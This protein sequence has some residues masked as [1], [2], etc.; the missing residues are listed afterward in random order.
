MTIG[1]PGKHSSG[2]SFREN[3][4]NRLGLGGDEATRRRRG[5]RSMSVRERRA[6]IERRL[7]SQSLEAR[8]LLAGPE[9]VGIQPNSGELI[10]GGTSIDSAPLF[11]TDLLQTAP[12]ELR[13]R[14]DS[15]SSIDVATLLNPATANDDTLLP[16]G[17]SITRA[18]SDQRFETAT[19]LTD[20]GT[21][22]NATENRRV[23]VEFRAAA[24]GVSGNG[25]TVRITNASVA[26]SAA[27]VVIASVDPDLKTIDIRLNTNSPRPATVSDL[28]ETLE[29]HPTANQV[30]TAYSV[31]GLTTTAIN[32]NL[33][34]T[35]LT[36]NLDGANTARATTDLG[37]GDTTQVRFLANQSGAA[38]RDISIRITPANLGSSS[39][40]LVSV[41]NNVINVRINST[42]GAQTTVGQLV[43]A[44][45]NSATAA[46][47]VTASL[48][49]GSST[50]LIST[51][52]TTVTAATPTGLPLTG[53]SDTV[54]S[55][56]FVGIGDTAN[57]VVFRFAEPLP[58]D[59]YQIEIYGEGERALLNTAGEAFNDGE[60]FAVQF[61]I[62]AAPQVLA[63]VPEPVTK[64]SDG[65]LISEPNVIEVYFTNDVN[66][67][68]LNAN[69]Y[70][71]VFTR[72]TVTG[73]DDEAIKPIAVEALDG[74]TDAVRV[75][76]N[77]PFSRTP[78]P[79]NPGSSIE[80]SVRF[81]IGDSTAL[82]AAPIETPVT[83]AESGDSIYRNAASPIA[84]P[85][86]MVLTSF[87]GINLTQ[88]SAIRLTGGSIE[89]AL[90]EILQFPGGS[91]YEGV[92]DIR[93]DDPTSNDRVV[94]LGIWRTDGDTTAGIS[95]I[96]YN[97]PD[98]WQGE[99]FGTQTTDLNETY[100]NAI[101]EQQKERVREVASLFSEY[102]GIQFIEVGQDAA[103]AI[104]SPD[105]TGEVGPVYSIGVGELSSTFDGTTARVNSAA[106]GVTVASRELDDQGNTFLPFDVDSLPVNGNQLI[107]LDGQDFDQSTDDFTG[108]EFFRGVFLGIGQLLG[109]GYAD[110]LPQPIT[111]STDSV[112][113]PT[114]LSQDAIP[115]TTADLLDTNESL[116]PSP[117]DIVNG[118]FLYRPESNDIDLYQFTLANKGTLNISTI[119]ERLASSST[120]DTMLRLYK[121]EGGLPIEIAANDDYFSNDSMIEIEVEK[122]T[123]V[124]GVS[125]SGNDQYDPI[126]A[127]TGIGGVSEGDYEVAM[128]FTPT[129]TTLSAISD[130]VN[131]LDGDADGEEGGLFQFWFEPN[132]AN[133]TVYVDNS[134]TT[135]GT[136]VAGSITN[137][138]STLNQAFTSVESRRLTDNPVEV[139]RV[140]SGGT[141]KIGRT[142]LGSALT[143]GEL[144]TIDVPKDVN[145]V[146]DAGVRFEMSGS[147]IGVGSTSASVDRSGSSIQVLGTPDSP[148]ELV[149]FG[150]NPQKGTWGGIEIRGDI[151]Y[152]DDSRTNMEENG[153][154]LNHIQYADIQNAGGQVRVDGGLRTVSAIE[155]AESR[156]TIINSMIT[157]SG[158]AAIAATPN[159]F[160]ETRFDE[161]RFQNEIAAGA[162][163]SDYFTSDFV[164]IGPHIRGNT[165]T[166]NTYN[167]L[168]IRIST[169]SGGS[170]ETLDLNARFD[171]TDIVH[172]LIENLLIEG[173]P[174]GPVSLSESPSLLLTQAT[175]AVNTPTIDNGDIPQGQYAYRMTYVTRDGFESAASDAS[176]TVTLSAT[177]AIE[178]NNL[179]T[180]VSGTDYTGRRLY[181]AP[182]TGTD[183]NGQP[184]YG[185]FTRVGRLNTSDTSFTDT[186]ATGLT[187]LDPDRIGPASLALSGRLDPGLTID[188]GTIV[189][190][191]DARIEVTFGSR[192]YAEGTD[193][194]PIVLTSLND[195]RYGTGGTF[196]TNG[197]AQDSTPGAPSGGDAG[198]WAGIYAAF[199]A[200]VS[201][202]HGVI[203]GGGGTSR[204][205]GGFA[206]FNVIEAHQ[207]DLRIANT[208]FENNDDGRSF[209]ND[210]SNSNN[211]PDDPREQRVGR[212]NNASGTI[213]VRGSQPVIIGNTFIDGNGPT[214]TFDVNS[215]TWQEQTDPGRSTG[216]IDALELRGNSGPLI[217][218]NLIENSSDSLAGLEVRGGTVATEVVWDDTDIVH[219][220]RDT[221]E[222]PNQHIYGGLRIESD[223]RASLVVKF[224]TLGDIPEQTIFIT[225]VNTATEPADLPV[226]GDA[227]FVFDGSLD[228][229]GDFTSVT[230][231]DAT[232]FDF[233]V[234]IGDDF[235]EVTIL[236]TTG[237]TI[238]DNTF[239]GIQLSPEFDLGAFDN[240]TL[241]IGG[242]SLNGFDNSR[243][244]VI[245]GVMFLNIAGLTFEPNDVIRIDTGTIFPESEVPFQE[246]ALLRRQAGIVVGGNSYTAEDEL[247]GIADRIGGSL[248][249]IGQPDFPVVL[250]SLADDTVGAGFT[251]SGLANLNTDGA[252]NTP[253]PGGWDGIVIREAASDSNASITSE[254]EPSNVGLSDTN[255]VASRAQFVG[256]VAP[257]RA[258]GDENRQLGLI[259]DGE[260]SSASDVDVYS[261]VA[262]AGTQVWL[263]IDRT[264]LSVDTVIELVNANGQ[265]LVLS[266]DAMAEAALI[267]ELLSLDAA[268][269][270]T[271]A[272]REELRALISARTGR[273]DQ[274]LDIDSIFG[275]ATGQIDASAGLVAF[276]DNYSINSRD[277]GMRV[278]L[279]GVVGQRTLYHVRVRSAIST[280]AK[281]TL[282]SD[283][284]SPMVV[285]DT[286][287]VA[288]NEDSL[289]SQTGGLRNGLTKGSYQLQIRIEESDVSAG[290]QIR[291]S[292][293]MYADNGV[294]IIGGPLHSPLAGEDFETASDN[295]TFG[296]A[297]RLGL[298]DTQF[299]GDPA[300]DPAAV[301]QPDGSILISRD[302][303]TVDRVDVEL[304]N[305]AGPLSSDRLAKNISGFIDDTNDVDWF[306]FEIEYQQL[307]R[308]DAAMYLATVFD[309]D[310]ADGASRADLSLYVFDAA[311]NLVLIG[312]DSNIADDMNSSGATS[313][314]DLSR[315]SYGTADPY[316][317]SAELPEGT[318][319]VAIS[320]KF[321]APA[322]LDQFTTRNPTNPLIRLEPVDSTRRIAEEGFE[323]LGNP[324]TYTQVAEGPVVQVL[325]DNNSIIEHTLDDV[326]LYVNSGT[327]LFLV[328][329]FTGAR[330][331]T[332]GGFG[333]TI[334]DVAFT[335]N[336][337]LFGYTVPQQLDDGNYTYAR[338]DTVNGT[339]TPLENTGIET[340]HDLEI[341]EDAVQVLDE[342]SDDGLIVEAITIRNRFG[343]E[344]GYLVADR[345][346]AR[347]GLTPGLNFNRQGY[348]TNILYA[349][350]E[351]TGEAT[352]PDFD[353]TLANAGAGTNIREVGQIDTSQDPDDGQP[354]DANVIGISSATEINAAGVAVP[355]LFDGDNFTLTNG[356]QFVTFEL[357]QG[358]TLI[359]TDPASIANGTTLSVT[360]PGRTPVTFELTNAPDPTTPGNVIVNIDRTASNTVFI[361]QL[362]AAIQAQSPGIP[363][364]FKGTQLAFPTATA[365]TLT[366]PNANPVSG[367]TLSGSQLVQPGR[368]PVTLLPTDSAE[369]IANRIVQAI[370][371]QNAGGALPTVIGTSLGR[372]VQI[373][374][375]VVDAN[376]AAGNLRLGGFANGGSITGIELV[377]NDLYAVSDAGGL[378]RVPSGFLGINGSAGSNANVGQY[379]ASSTD[380]IGINFSGLRAGP[381]SLRD[382]EGRQILFGIT[383]N[384][385]IHAFNLDGELQ[386]VFA[387][388]RTSISTGIG[389]AQGLDFA[390]LDYNLWHVT[391]ARDSDDGHGIND[392]YH[393]ARP[394]QGD[395]NNS[396]VFN[397][398]AAAFN[399]NYGTG[400]APVQNINTAAENVRQDGQDVQG[401]Y[402]F[403]GGARGT[404]QSNAF[405]LEGY[406]AADL[407]TMYFNYFLETDGVDDDSASD[408]DFDLFGEDQD[409]LRV[410]VVDQHGVEHLVA[411]NNEQRRDGLFD[412]EFDDP[413][414][415]GVYDDSIDV[416]VQQLYDN[417]G[418]W[419][420]ARVS[421]E[422][423]AGQSGLSLRIEFS[424]AGT[425][426][427]LSDE[428]RTVAASELIDG[429]TLIINGE[430]F[431]I[432][433]AP[434][435]TFSS[436][437]SLQ[438]LYQ[439]PNAT[440]TF[441]VDGQTYLLNDGTR[442]VPAGVISINL[443]AD[444]PVGATLAEL[445][446]G[447][448]ARAVA[449]TFDTQIDLARLL[450]TGTEIEQF[451][452]ANP[453]PIGVDPDTY[454]AENPDKLFTVY[455]NGTEFVLLD[456]DT[457]RSDLT[458]GFNTDLFARRS[459]V[460]VF[461]L[462]ELLSINGTDATSL[463][464]LS[465]DDVAFVIG[466]LIGETDFA[467]DYSQLVPTANILDNY[468]TNS[469]A[470]FIVTIDDVE[471]VLNDGLR[472][473][474]VNQVS[475]PL[476]SDVTQAD[477]AGELQAIVES[478]FGIQ[479]PAYGSIDQFD[480]SDPSDPTDPFG[481]PNPA[482]E[483]GRN[484]LTYQATPIAY[485]GG[486][487][488]V[489]GRGTL[490]TITPTLITNR[491]DI[492]LVS[493][494][495]L[496]AGTTVSVSVTSDQPGVDN[497]VRFFDEDGIELLAAGGGT[498][499]VENIADGTISVVIPSNGLYYIGIS[500]PE[501]STYDP[502][503]SGTADAAQTGGYAASISI[504]ADMNI[505]A[506]G[507]SVEF[508]GAGIVSVGAAEVTDGA[509]G[510][511]AASNQK[512]LTGTPISV[513]RGD[514]AA[515]VA[516]ALQAALAERFAGGDTSLI[517]VAGSAVRLPNLNFDA[518][519]LG[520]FVSTAERYGD[521][522]GGDYQ[523]GASANDSE[524]AYIDDIIIGFAER[525]EMVTAATPIGAEEAFVDS[526]E[527][528]LTSP[529]ESP[530]PTSSGSYQLEIRDA[531]EYIAS[532]A[533][534]ESAPNLV[535]ARFRAFDTNE[536]LVSSSVSLVTKPA[537]EILDG[538]TFTIAG[539]NNRVTFE[540][541]VLDAA[542]NSNGF[543]QNANRVL[544]QIAADATAEE[545]ADTI[546]GRIS[547][548]QVS[549]VL[550]VSAMRG[551][552]TRAN[553]P[554]SVPDTRINLSGATSIRTNAIGATAFVSTTTDDL[555]GDTNRDRTEQGV[556]MIEN[557]RFIYN[558]DAGLQISRDASESVISDDPIDATPSLV[559]YARN[560]LELNTENLIP[561]V[562][563]RNNT[564]AFNQDVGIDIS[565]LENSGFASENPV[566]FDRILNNTLVGGT[567]EQTANLGSQI[568]ESTFF[569]LG[570]ISF[571]DSVLDSETVHG[572]DVEESF[573]DSEAAL[574][575][576]DCFGVSTTDPENGLFT[577]SLGSGGSA[578]FAF[579]DNLLTGSSSNPSA[580]M[581]IG[582]GIDDLV[583]FETGIPERVRVE[584][585]RD[586]VTYFNVGEIFG[587][588]NKIDL[589]AFGFGLSDRFSYV[590]LTDLSPSGTNNFGPGGADID[591]VG[592][593][594]TVPRDTFVAGQTGIRVAD[595][596]APTLLNNVVSNFEVGL[597][598]APTPT[599]AS[600]LIDVSASLT[601]I[602][603]TTYYR[604]DLASLIAGIDGIGQSAQ[605]IDA[606]DSVFVDAF[607]LIF[608]PQSRTPIIDSGI[609]SLEDRASLI[610]LRNSLGLPSSPILAPTFDANGQ[611]RVD[612]PT[613]DTSFGVG[614][615]GFIDRGA[616]ERTDNEGP[617][618]VLTSPRGQDLIFDQTRDLFGRS[619][620]Q[621]TI[622]DAFEIQLIDGIVPADTGYGVGV[623]DN[624]VTSEN[625]LVTRL[626]VGSTTVELLEEGRDYKFSYEPSDNTIRITPIAGIWADNAVY[627]VEFLGT[628]AGSADG[629]NAVLKAETG[630]EYADGEK[631][632][633]DG[634]ILET[635]LGIQ[636]AVPSA[637]LTETDALTGLTSSA[638]NGQTITVFDGVNTPVTFEFVTDITEEVVNGIVT[639]T[640][641]YAIRLPSTASAQRVALL[642]TQAI[643]D[644]SASQ[645]SVLNIEAVY[646]EDDGTSTTGRMQLLGTHANSDLAYVS[647]DED[648]MFRQVN[649]ELDVQ[650]LPQIDIDIDGSRLTNYNETIVVFDGTREV[651][652]EFDTDG[653]IAAIDPDV[654]R[655]VLQV[656]ADA[657]LR[658]LV[659]ALIQGFQDED[660]DLQ[661]SGASGVFRVRGTNG[662]IS[663]T[664]LNGG[665][666][667]TGNSSIGVSLGFGMQI[668]TTE[669]EISTAVED[670]QTFTIASGLGTP[671]TFEIDFDGDLLD[672]G[673][674][675]VTV[676]GG[677]FGGSPDA[678]AN[679]IVS[680][681]SL[682][683][684]SLTPINHGGGKI[685]LGGDSDI[686]LSTAGTVI[687]QVGSPGDPASQA[688]VIRYNDDANTVAEAFGDAALAA[689]LG[690]VDGTDVRQ[691]DNRVLLKTDTTPIG[692]AVVTE[693][694]ADKAGNRLQPASEQV[695]SRVEILVGE[696]SDYGDASLTFGNGQNYPTTIQTGGPSHT[697]VDNDDDVLFLG[698]SVT[699]DVNGSNDDLD[700]DDGVIQL[701][702]LQPG[703]TS[704]FEVSI[705]QRAGAPSPSQTS[706][707]DVWFDWDGD[708]AFEESAGEVNRFTFPANTPFLVNTLEI[709]VPSTAQLGDV[710][711]RFRLSY[712]AGLGPVGATNAGE[713]EDYVYTV[714]NNPFTG[715]TQVEDVNDS[716]A[717]TP[718][719]ALLIINVL[720]SNGGGVDLTNV[721][722]G[723]SLPKYPDVNGDG[724]ITEID[725]LRVINWLNANN[726]PGE[727]PGSEPLASTSTQSVAYSP[728]AEG[729]MA[730]NSTIM[731]DPTVAPTSTQTVSSPSGEP[732]PV[733]ADSP[734][735]DESISETSKTSV[736]DSPATMQLD[737]IVDTLAQDR[738]DAQPSRSDDDVSVLDDFFAELG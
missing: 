596:A 46:N 487:L 414:Q 683:F 479:T 733:A 606:S 556:I 735:L 136:G 655:V 122:G 304:N 119:A 607:N 688:V 300:L 392:A 306:E 635:E 738:Q 415:I 712:E 370:A 263:D 544:V 639:A 391:S 354:D 523:A 137:P 150:T 695:S 228:E 643:N 429:E 187:P 692:D 258:S 159:T 724:M 649:Q 624:T 731:F 14:F 729:V 297:Q 434:V 317:G 318:Y 677:G 156:A 408:D 41:A 716:G 2:R 132:D 357:N 586:N 135:A 448:I 161:S 256:E 447:D 12:N 88:T 496:A 560:F 76:F 140:V 718:L 120:L 185:E 636:L 289:Q 608:T 75:I 546:I 454:Y 15:N 283:G 217:K 619:I 226:P 126:I 658:E 386:A 602:G 653:I 551:N 541:D 30:V 519:Q 656:A 198:D 435:V 246:D 139:V 638:I 327:E 404:V 45:N 555:R 24:P 274:A 284:K 657:S 103:A 63:V 613:F 17:L 509:A 728:V 609:A 265:T 437:I 214:M 68:V 367:L 94:P 565:G 338:I 57:E 493:I 531:S 3:L 631:T 281:S 339:I 426:S 13:F 254:N 85:G 16:L 525:G 286:S 359:S 204:V 53:A 37:L 552:L 361:E 521:R 605:F 403:P 567:I 645:P 319:Y 195:R 603:G 461:S 151:D 654:D 458:L 476:G 305:G 669:G 371:T 594:S 111:Q 584:I 592:A 666:L 563:V 342:D 262:E 457:Q 242:T 171:D 11:G 455:L 702:T 462:F 205:E 362:A 124:V 325:F 678:L 522:F 379:I 128:T 35:G 83:E 536:R 112:L 515:D 51:T 72:D 38:G 703:F 162:G 612:D 39:T 231:A 248:Q 234:E 209:V 691:I 632:F 389:N 442:T 4:A 236:E 121:I 244:I 253:T 615:S 725:A 148:V 81:R 92:R 641:N 321:Q 241:D 533:V 685:T 272:R 440:S 269:P 517:P 177:G 179:P 499:A 430:S 19:A 270:N 346:V 10:R 518:D 167:G 221:I 104:T 562:V 443:L 390:T 690:G 375:V 529:A 581:G 100:S 585:S 516:I 667:I 399:G 143:N 255:A 566:G 700:I 353:L 259:V 44:I 662:P 670:G 20:F 343:E 134:G 460:D 646:L 220:V 216:G 153:V 113:D 473:V 445:T 344:T 484:D 5:K 382:A 50:G 698:G 387:G 561:G 78:D 364:S 693:F 393:G 633:I 301:V 417:T 492:D 154:F 449:E 483:L 147:R 47:L 347:Q 163:L 680:A 110:H 190:L 131:I 464:D 93:P 328:N 511:L 227:D 90:G 538:S 614:L 730:T 84:E 696:L 98:E 481:N 311:G 273:G 600:G 438:Q 394:D 557:S 377:G 366:P 503:I 599:L 149:G 326:F 501:N 97:F 388:G 706:Y 577:F 548:Q 418:T 564:F 307:T 264:N 682:T 625:L 271:A 211:N 495:N 36:L 288:D 116:F 676:F 73:G 215:F 181:R 413:A 559:T 427:T 578:V 668:P 569:P 165:I 737:G 56:G 580:V 299:S 732:M 644:L 558:E 547:S 247:N 186:I 554:G 235:V 488:I 107:V 383:S 25:T 309:I 200:D 424:T 172:I 542:G 422:E 659:Q 369:T 118:Q 212:V 409:T 532:G 520:P 23:E 314:S 298:Y 648:A 535:D 623:N 421:L 469:D 337:E 489:N 734:S 356:T 610:S 125:A 365:V 407:P 142:Q 61:E 225:A 322:Q 587:L 261:F 65:R 285:G 109:Y 451:Y 470:V 334:L 400:E 152:A 18:G 604:N 405:S 491:G 115:S 213:F 233:G 396:L 674:T 29:N 74:R 410:Y 397:Y 292:D 352:G 640:G 687:E 86:P 331:A 575:S 406:S 313:T 671:V 180:V 193:T 513:S 420:Q 679:A 543:A 597:S 203:A 576:P 628:E 192:L 474:G 280:S 689:G 123:Y 43:T 701:G 466:S 59:A 64:Q 290:T 736:F 571:A 52:F 490:G 681:V 385:D 28:L 360:L 164:R 506:S 475:V 202:D 155:L 717:V 472:N 482:G 33:P 621:G 332:L 419:R 106:G 208:R 463:D 439:D 351:E 378:Y 341:E 423:F 471:F 637:A 709:A 302:S 183:V 477:V 260:L 310:Y 222:V 182:V 279:P 184:I 652:F 293:V 583:I 66:S 277:A 723:L 102:L 485:S 316:I 278:I 251:P 672:A 206:S 27:P 416:D 664:A 589:D 398:T 401:T 130:G 446:A 626:V 294:Q 70:T 117:A 188:P 590:R 350:D 348:T 79:D 333:T 620:T 453:I 467:V 238:V 634:Q 173:N 60:D 257:D 660:L 704:D 588:E 157:Q 627:T 330:Y 630:L 714:V 512:P 169:P 505:V 480:F 618:F 601:V 54:V 71:A 675:P 433:M 402:N 34:A 500:G 21:S 87:N 508:G 252:N 9:L 711:A 582:D 199:G 722:A 395:A 296:N 673:A 160:A 526:G 345:P 58:D 189:K 573:T 31:H 287:N 276:Q 196:N 243:L 431:S 303:A 6:T 176:L 622:Y 452:D 507:A 8:Q 593:I 715:R 67:S 514:S 708:G 237:A 138:F 684:P 642:L 363:V 101:T 312:G 62:N 295:G 572:P 194:A 651:A 210:S 240:A 133:T 145:L 320:N 524:G 127:G 528:S 710:Q 291:Y 450:P 486:N 99:D 721:P 32:T 665:A 568:F 239:A 574:G 497:N 591:A 268:D 550:G 553:T 540:F 282:T 527:L 412:D 579:D 40:P 425:T 229:P 545:V 42:A 166:D 191:N 197:L 436:G 22:V 616:E 114:Q 69:Y 349:F 355:Q 223:A 705:N 48:Q 697:I 465:A 267:E 219:I 335:A 245:N 174:G 707:L 381:N 504:E 380:L 178:L 444:Q 91:D 694:I 201:I 340:S 105:F 611:L 1:K 7:H 158:D 376:S 80:G 324:S 510:G 595:N 170:T 218:G 308:D 411:T 647:F 224:D 95:T 232:D 726:R 250:T 549:T 374:G 537:S 686:R 719:D 650:L 108:G 358:Y 230:P 49:R 89:N 55:P 713:V 720:N 598:V 530:R 329:P 275:L 478:T 727:V 534:L 77:S 336:G 26:G 168:L 141:Y 372:A 428:I 175:G 663:L 441:T 498:L 459:Q 384:G 144:T 468:Y 82:P 570:A 661:A 617:R 629:Y 456:G 146:L 323:N 96:Y 539:E 207:S 699:A 266:D 315:G 249:V 502:R 368:V 494:G 373:T 129:T 432:D